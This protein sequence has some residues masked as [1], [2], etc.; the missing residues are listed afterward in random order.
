MNSTGAK[1]KAQLTCR[2]CRAEVVVCV[3]ARVA[4]PPEVWCDHPSH[5]PVD[6]DARGDLVCPDCFNPWHLSGE[7]LIDAIEDTLRRH[8]D[9]WARVGS[10]ELKCG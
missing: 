4:S 2:R 10:V 5:G 9:Y 7:A 3:P 8:L 6:K 1:L